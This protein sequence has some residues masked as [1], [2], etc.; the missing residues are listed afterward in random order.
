MSSSPLLYPAKDWVNQKIVLY[1]GTIEDY[2]ENMTTDLIDV[3]R[4]KPYR[5]FGPGFYTTTLYRQAEYWAYLLSESRRAAG[6]EAP[7]AVVEVALP[8]AELAG[9]RALGFIRG[10]FDA[11]DFW[12]FVSYCR[13]GAVNHLIG[14]TSKIQQLYDV[15]YGPVA[16]DWRQRAI[17]EGADQISFH[18]EAAQSLLNASSRRRVK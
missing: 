17:F 8:R 5:D 9:L 2:A 4:G 11:E 7:A 16:A 6:V 14:G 15:V 3:R 13:S 10:D 18:T 1:H 12:S